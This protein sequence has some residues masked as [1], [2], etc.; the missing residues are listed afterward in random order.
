MSKTEMAIIAN[1]RYLYIFDLDYSYKKVEID[2]TYPEYILGN[3][4]KL[5]KWIL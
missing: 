3:K 4:E 1:K 2:S 5:K